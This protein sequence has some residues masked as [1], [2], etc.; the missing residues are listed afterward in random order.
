MEVGRFNTECE[1]LTCCCAAGLA[2]AERL[3][4]LFWGSLLNGC[5]H[6]KSSCIFALLQGCA[7]KG[8][9]HEASAMR[10][11]GWALKGWVQWLVV[12]VLHFA[13]WHGFVQD[14]FLLAAPWNGL[15]QERIWQNRRDTQTSKHLGSLKHP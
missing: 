8:V 13:S 10:F 1:V 15:V 3:A 7:L 2:V 6:D 9:V 14:A 12:K 5:V 11:A 4:W